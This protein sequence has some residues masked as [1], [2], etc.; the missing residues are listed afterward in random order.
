MNAPTT[1][2]LQLE[3]LRLRDFNSGD[4]EDYRALR[5]AP[6]VA[7]FYPPEECSRAFAAELL[8]GFVK[9]SQQNPR[10]RFQL[11]IEGE[12][13]EFMGSCG[14]RLENE[15]AGEASFGCELLPGFWGKGYA[16]EAGHGIL[17]FGLERL[18]LKEVV[19]E[20]LA[21]NSAALVLAGKLG[22]VKSGKVL[23]PRHFRGRAWPRVHLHLRREQLGKLRRG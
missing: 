10:H 20:T 11:V 8:Q 7:A 15:V 6:Q 21:D 17:A 4:L 13:G 23:E 12:A 5:Q 18:P 1:L 2:P 19:A 3:R 14:I 9:Q 16:L 22:F